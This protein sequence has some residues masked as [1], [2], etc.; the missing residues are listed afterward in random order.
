MLLEA[1]RLL[2]S[3]DQSEDERGLTFAMPARFTVAPIRTLSICSLRGRM[4][5]ERTQGR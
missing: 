2:D 3:V 5:H 1:L 4:W